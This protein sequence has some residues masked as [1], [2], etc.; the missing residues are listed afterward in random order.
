M[1]LSCDYTSQ[2]SC[3]RE[4]GEEKSRGGGGSMTGVGFLSKRQEFHL[5]LKGVGR[6]HMW[7]ALE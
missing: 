7:M 1:I 4:E 5:R 3:E 6:G 2:L